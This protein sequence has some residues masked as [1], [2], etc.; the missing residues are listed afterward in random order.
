MVTNCRGQTTHSQFTRVVNLV[1]VVLNLSLSISLLSR[2]LLETRG[3][4]PLSMT[5]FRVQVRLLRYEDLIHAPSMYTL[6][7]VE[8]KHIL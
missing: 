4:R 3:M 6:I 5:I 2:H 1:V 7:R 8:K